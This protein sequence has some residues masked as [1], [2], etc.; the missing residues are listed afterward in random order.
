[1]KIKEITVERLKNLGNYESA[2]LNVTAQLDEEDNVNQ[3]VEDL[4]FFLDFK[5]NEGERE[6]KM[7]DI[8]IE[9]EKG[10]LNEVALEK[11]NE[12][13]AKYKEAWER[14]NSLEFNK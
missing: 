2:R 10:D 8:S 3:T 14:F 12:W 11:R 4:A 7:A 5:L 1:M 13:I 9:L 6:K